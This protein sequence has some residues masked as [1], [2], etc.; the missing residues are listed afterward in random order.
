MRRMWI[1]FALGAL[2][3]MGC[4]DEAPPPPPFP[5]LVIPTPPP[6]PSTTGEEVPGF[7]GL[8]VPSGGQGG[9]PPHGGTDMVVYEYPLARDA[10]AAAARAVLAQHGWTIDSDETS[11]RGSVR[12]VVTRGQS[13][14][15]LRVA[16][17]GERAAL[18]VTRERT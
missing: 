17:E 10:L 4:S 13:T 2:C 16:G 5:Q 11:P 15:D 1:V 8:F 6:V 12:M 18:I 7:P 9:P 3:A 14:V